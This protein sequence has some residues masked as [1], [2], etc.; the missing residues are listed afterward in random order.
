[1]SFFFFK[2]CQTQIP[3]GRIIYFMNLHNTTVK[4][5]QAGETR[6]LKIV[7]RVQYQQALSDLVWGQGALD[8]LHSCAWCQGPLALSSYTGR[9][10]NV[11]IIQGLGSHSL[12]PLGVRNLRTG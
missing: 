2:S 7:P 4:Q 5:K 10:K 9:S 1:M 11:F 3:R 6:T 12:I 8:R